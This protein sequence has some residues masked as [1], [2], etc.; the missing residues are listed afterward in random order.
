MAPVRTFDDALAAE[1][2]G[3]RSGIESRFLA[4]GEILV[5]SIEGI[6]TLITSLD[7]LIKAL[8][9]NAVADTTKD[10]RVAAETLLGLSDNHRDRLSAMA[11]LGRHREI[12]AIHVGDM[13]SSLAYMRAFTVNIKIVSSGIAEAGSTFESFAQEISD[14]I[15]AGREELLQVELDIAD[16]KRGLV[17]ASEESVRLDSHLRTLL[18]ALP[19]QLGES[20]GRMAQHYSR[21]LLVADEVAGIARNIHKRVVRVLQALQIGDSTRQ[22]IEHVQAGLSFFTRQDAGSDP[23]YASLCHA[24]LKNQLA[25]TKGEF[26]KEVGE[27]ERAMTD[28]ADQSREL[29]KLR[30]MAYG[31]HSEKGQ[32]FLDDLLARIE[33]SLVLVGEIEGADSAAL[34]TGRD[35]AEATAHLNTRISAIQSLKN[36]VQYMALNTTIRCAQ[37]GEVARPLSVIAIELRDHGHHLEV[38]A[39]NGLTELDALTAAAGTLAAAGQSKGELS[40]TEA[41][42]IAA[43]LIRDARARTESEIGILVSRG[44]EVLSIL[45]E[46]VERLAFDTEIGRKLDR[47]A[48]YLTDS[49]VD[50][51]LDA[52]EFAAPLAEFLASAAALYTMKQEREVHQAFVQWLGLDLAVRAA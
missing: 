6:D 17:A 19:N 3:A 51:P 45:D 34:K 20:A 52:P 50:R 48:D 41:L 11:L 9:E 26:D 28:M 44:E 24:L 38:A 40:A 14:C 39:N 13:R 7:N 47:V 42:G 4:A 22:R 2:E 27:I 35:T 23:R 32:G 43:R 36:D 21:V 18:P 49:A 16:L 37:I 31:S 46:S 33:E 8:D 29:L 15:E 25:A 1:L 10:M 30:D 12:L 5:R